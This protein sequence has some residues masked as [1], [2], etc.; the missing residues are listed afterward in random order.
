M[1]QKTQSVPYL[2][3]NGKKTKKVNWDGINIVS[4]KDEERLK[5][6]WKT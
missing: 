5:E 2:I 1:N 4:N 6:N 3:E